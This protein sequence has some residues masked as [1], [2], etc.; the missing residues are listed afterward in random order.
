MR[1]SQRATTGSSARTCRHQTSASRFSVVLAWH[2]TRPFSGNTHDFKIRSHTTR[3]HEANDASSEREPPELNNGA[4]PTIH[5]DKKS[6]LRDPA[7]LDTQLNHGQREQ[8]HDAND[9]NH[10]TNGGDIQQSRFCTTRLRQFVET[11]IRSVGTLVYFIALLYDEVQN[12]P[13][14]EVAN[15]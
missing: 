13:A 8:D 12:H 6:F 1:V 7:G 11:P 5:A 15:H 2:I 9:R 3:I 10:D 4:A 14:H